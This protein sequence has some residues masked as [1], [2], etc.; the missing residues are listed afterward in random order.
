MGDTP[1]S[2]TSSDDDAV[3]VPEMDPSIP[4][5]VF[6]RIVKSEFPVTDEGKPA[7][8]V[9]RDAVAILLAETEDMIVERFTKVNEVAQLQN[10]QTIYASDSQYVEGINRPRPFTVVEDDE[11]ADDAEYEGGEDA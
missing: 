9:S 4:Q 7:L 10:R 8:H 5:S 3:V 11:V 6:R 1:S 2:T